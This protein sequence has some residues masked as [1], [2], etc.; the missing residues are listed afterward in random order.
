MWTNKGF[1]I[2]CTG[3]HQLFTQNGWKQVKDINLHQDFLAITNSYITSTKKNAINENLSILLS[4][5]ISEGSCMLK[6]L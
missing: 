1:F 2:D 5:V 4:Y 3:D 6:I